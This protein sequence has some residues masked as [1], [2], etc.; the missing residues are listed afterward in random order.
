MKSNNETMIQNASGLKVE[1]QV[2]AGGLGNN[3]NETLVRDAKPATGLKVKTRVKAGVR[4]MNHN[5]T[6]AVSTGGLRVKTRVNAGG[7]TVKT[8]LNGGGMPDHNE[9]LVRGMKVRTNLKAGW[10]MFPKHVVDWP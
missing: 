1:T 2:K 3:R 6:V 8:R 9:T 5:E 7:L 10:S 4:A